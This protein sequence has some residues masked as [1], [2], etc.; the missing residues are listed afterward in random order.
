MAATHHEIYE[1][2]VWATAMT[3]NADAAAE[4]FTEDGVIEA[5]L[6]GADRIFPRRMQGRE[7]IRRE[8]A[9]YYARPAKTA[10]TVNA[11][12]SRYV[13]HA[14]ADPAVFIVEIDAAFNEPAE[15]KTMSL[16]QIFRIRDGKIAML[17]DY[18]AS[19]E[20]E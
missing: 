17:R 7:E 20:V 2:Y 12:V 16:V 9:A 19:D 4:L 1:R 13:L 8:L 3:R 15:H 18:F 6:L 11:N 14:T 10:R 5:P